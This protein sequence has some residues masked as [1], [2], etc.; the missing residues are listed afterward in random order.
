MEK[1][2]IEYYL[3]GNLRLVRAH[4][5]EPVRPRLELNIGDGEWVRLS[6]EEAD[7]VLQGAIASGLKKV[8]GIL[9]D[10]LQAEED[11]NERDT[12]D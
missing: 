12:L 6:T 10:L 1:K 9:I 8:A 11:E 7:F 5:V 3:T 2:V 4:N